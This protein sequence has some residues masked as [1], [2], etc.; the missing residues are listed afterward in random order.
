MLSVPFWP[1]RSWTRDCDESIVW[2]AAHLR[3][4]LWNPLRGSS[5]IKFEHELHIWWHC[6]FGE[7]RGLN[8]RT[9][10]SSNFRVEAIP[11]LFTGFICTGRVRTTYSIDHVA[12]DLLLGVGNKDGRRSHSLSVRD[13]STATT[14]FASYPVMAESVLQTT[15]EKSWK[16]A[17]SS[18]GWVSH[19]TTTSVD[20]D[21]RVPDPT[22]D[23][24][25]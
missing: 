22:A 9:A 1:S 6:E 24:V 20:M 2:D 14:S 15:W 4:A 3:L 17:V 10:T 7:I 12:S 5:R 16:I 11:R 19:R 8:S 13:G 25:I 18:C 23:E 21:Q